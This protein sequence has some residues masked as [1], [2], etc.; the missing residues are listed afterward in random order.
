MMP[1]T[2][3]P[4]RSLGDRLAEDLS[5]RDGRDPQALGKELRLR[6]LAAAGRAEKITRHRPDYRPPDPAPLEEPLVV[7][8]DELDSICWTVSIATPTTIRSEV[9]P[10]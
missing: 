8:L 1:W 7:A 3:G 6:A 5:R 9:P 10:K 2:G 4:A